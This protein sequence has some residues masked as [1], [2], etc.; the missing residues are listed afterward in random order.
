MLSSCDMF[1]V[2]FCTPLICLQSRDGSVLLLMLVTMLHTH[3]SSWRYLCIHRIPQTIAITMFNNNIEHL[4]AQMVTSQKLDHILMV[5][6]PQGPPITTTC[7]TTILIGCGARDGVG[8]PLPWRQEVGWCWLWCLAEL[9]GAALAA[10]LFRVLRR[11]EFVEAP[12]RRSGTGVPGRATRVAPGREPWEE[13]LWK[14]WETMKNH[15]KPWECQAANDQSDVLTPGVMVST[16]ENNQI[17][18]AVCCNIEFS[19]I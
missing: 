6:G 9:L 12:V 19:Y 1:I 15:G 14:P 2:H 7:Y 18:S 4:I 13:P 8:P 5:E 10:L 11:E 3:S 17:R 16:A